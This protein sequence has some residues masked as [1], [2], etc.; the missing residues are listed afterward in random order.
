MFFGWSQGDAAEWKIMAGSE[1]EERRPHA[2]KY[3]QLLEAGKEPQLITSQET[4]AS[5]L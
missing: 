1:D 3:A 4:G 2:K 5:V